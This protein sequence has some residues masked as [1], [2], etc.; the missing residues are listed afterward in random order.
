MAKVKAGEQ[1]NANVTSQP[2]TGTTGGNG[3]APD[4]D[5]QKKEKAEKLFGGNSRVAEMR[6]RESEVNTNFNRIGRKIKS[7]GISE[8]A[9]GKIMEVLKGEYKSALDKALAAPY[10]EPAAESTTESFV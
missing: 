5:T 10:D 4:A 3:T 6:R 1:D 2:G 8:D 7:L 9:Q